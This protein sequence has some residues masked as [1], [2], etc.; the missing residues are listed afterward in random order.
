MHA[1]QLVKMDDFATRLREWLTESCG[2]LPEDI[3]VHRF[4]LAVVH[5]ASLCFMH[6][7][8]ALWGQLDGIRPSCGCLSAWRVCGPDQL[9]G[10]E[11]QLLELS[12]EAGEAPGD[13][14]LRSSLRND[15]ILRL[16]CRNV[17]CLAPIDR[18][19]SVFRSIWA[20]A[21]EGGTCRS[22]HADRPHG[23]DQVSGS[24]RPA[25]RCAAQFMRQG[26]RRWSGEWT[27]RQGG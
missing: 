27:H 22:D 2:Q 7:S 4:L 19:K 11:P 6:G 14:M 3:S 9:S 21:K 5:R 15:V 17:H 23:G 16:A 20:Q 26:R 24:F 25:P 10:N 13:A 18:T 12:V 8:E 1:F